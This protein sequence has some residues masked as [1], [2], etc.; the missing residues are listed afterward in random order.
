M[1]CPFWW[2][3]TVAVVGEI[4]IVM[5]AGATIFT[6]TVFETS[7]SSVVTLTG[8]DDFGA[9]ALPVAVNWVEDTKLVV[10]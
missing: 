2:T 7:P 9:G 5:G 4:A 1:N 10:S 6:K 8:T 3:R